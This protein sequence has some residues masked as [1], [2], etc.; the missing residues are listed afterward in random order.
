MTLRYF[1]LLISALAVTAVA[2][3]SVYAQGLDDPA[4]REHL[5]RLGINLDPL[6]LNNDNKKARANKPERSRYPGETDAH[7]LSD[8]AEG[9]LSE[10]FANA[11]LLKHIEAADFAP[12]LFSNP[13]IDGLWQSCRLSE[14]WMSAR[15]DDAFERKRT[16]AE[17]NKNK[18]E[19]KEALRPSID[20]IVGT[21]VFYT[22]GR[23]QMTGFDF[24]TM[25]KSLTAE[26]FD[27][28]RV[29][30]SPICLPQA[31]EA[32]V[33]SPTSGSYSDALYHN[34]N[35]CMARYSFDDPLRA[36][37]FETLTTTKPLKMFYF[38]KVADVAIDGRLVVELN[39][40][41][42]WAQ[43]AETQAWAK[44]PFT[45]NVT[46]S[47]ST[48]E[49]FQA[50][51]R[52]NLIQ[53]TQFGLTPAIESYPISKVTDSDLI[54]QESY[55]D[56]YLQFFDNGTTLF[57]RIDTSSR[58]TS[59]A[60]YELVERDGFKRYER[61]GL[62]GRNFTRH[63]VSFLITE[64][65]GNAVYQTKTQ[66]LLGIHSFGNEATELKPVRLADA[67]LRGDLQAGYQNHRAANTDTR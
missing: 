53:E 35:Q 40:V 2:A 23:I 9:V 28:A 16:L 45:L 44:T 3:N 64:T 26:A 60:R 49:H 25:S 1:A 54:Y 4:T 39:R 7:Y 11:A 17:F 21:E 50:I 22:R 42:M 66:A 18:D 15:S 41:E 10:T 20:R 62:S 19:I 8:I 24:D 56:H 52:R 46:D 47:R 5:E 65:E 59:Y 31:S 55:T 13:Y 67:K 58:G 38:G 12:G 6:N 34:G 36:E 30:C 32:Y 14:L 27:A 51:A 43:D 33:L 61:T 48:E 29:D 37:S 63:P 57:T